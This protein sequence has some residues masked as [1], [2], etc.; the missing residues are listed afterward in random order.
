MVTLTTGIMLPLFTCMHTWMWGIFR[1]CPAFAPT[2][3]EVV[4]DGLKFEKH[5]VTGHVTERLT[6]QAE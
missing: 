1:R 4:R 5:R 2:A 6:L 3:Y